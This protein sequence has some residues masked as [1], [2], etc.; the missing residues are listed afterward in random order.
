MVDMKVGL[1]V[2][3]LFL[4]A[5]CL[6]SY[7]CSG[8][9]LGLKSYWCR[10][11]DQCLAEVA[12]PECVEGTVTGGFAGPKLLGYRGTASGPPRPGFLTVVDFGICEIVFELRAVSCRRSYC[13]V[14]LWRLCESLSLQCTLFSVGGLRRFYGSAFLRHWLRLRVQLKELAEQNKE[15]AGDD[16]SDDDFEEGMGDIDVEAQPAM[17][18][19]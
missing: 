4:G 2:G 9:L 10:L 17:A 13:V 16:D 11:F 7:L 8:F 12:R 5:P 15:V 14:R 6:W 1:P 18:F 19:T 3:H